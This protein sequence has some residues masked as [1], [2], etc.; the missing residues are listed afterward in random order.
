MKKIFI[1][2]MGILL[3]TGCNEKKESKS[4]ISTSTSTT[5]KMTQTLNTGE[6]TTT[7]SNDEN[8][9]TNVEEKKTTTSTVKGDKTTSTSKAMTDKVK[10]STKNSS[11]TKT[12][13]TSTSKTSTSTSKK[14]TTTTKKP[15]TTTKNTLTEK[16]VYNKMIALKSKYPNGTP[17]GNDKCY[18]WKGGYITTGCGCAG[19]AFTLSDAAFG[20]RK[21][22]KHTDVSKIRVGDVLRVN[23]NT[24]S[25][26]VL[27]VDATGV[28]VAEGNMTFV[29]VFENGVYWGRKISTSELKSSLD[30]VLTRW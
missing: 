23:G 7:Q 3:V 18:N 21:A 26:I 13:T 16:E 19:F 27:A 10:T 15:T 9:T 6:E 11:K 24:H 22:T 12:T 8:I 4:D 25:V 5:T 29:G 30:Y 17:W 14:T 1:I 28:T 20:S 2:L